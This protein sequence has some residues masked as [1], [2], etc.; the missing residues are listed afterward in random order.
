[1]ERKAERGKR[2]VAESMLALAESGYVVLP[3]PLFL[4]KSFNL[5]GG[6]K[7]DQFRIKF[8]N[9]KPF[10]NAGRNLHFNYNIGIF[11]L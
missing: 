9:R 4:S 2:G 11:H 5:G 3:G 7:C 8:Q 10:D 1:M 6:G